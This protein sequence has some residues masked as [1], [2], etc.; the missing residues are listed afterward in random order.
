M[1]GFCADGEPVFEGRI[2]AGAVM[3]EQVA[4]G[5]GPVAPVSHD[6]C[7]LIR[8]VVACSAMWVTDCVYTDIGW[9]RL[10]P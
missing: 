7:A 9:S 5:A 2:E 4:D 8:P 10:H 3:G 1:L 6:Y